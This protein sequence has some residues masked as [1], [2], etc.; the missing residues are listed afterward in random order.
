[1]FCLVDLKRRWRVTSR[2]LL[3]DAR[4]G[5]TARKR[6]HWTVRFR[7]QLRD[8]RGLDRS[9]ANLSRTVAS[10]QPAQGERR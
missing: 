2:V 8:G 5:D 9:R 3:S 10:L 1:M 7:V 6:P 4:R